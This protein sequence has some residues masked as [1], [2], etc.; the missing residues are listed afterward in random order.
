LN[1]NVSFQ[2]T[3]F[4]LSFLLLRLLLLLIIQLSRIL[5]LL[6]VLLVLLRLVFCTPSTYTPV[7]SYSAFSFIDSPPAFSSALSPL[8]AS[9]P[10]RLRSLLLRLSF[11]L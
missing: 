11:H 10:S 4:L 7:S 3:E 6:C 8:S 9:F 1:S 2:H 5:L